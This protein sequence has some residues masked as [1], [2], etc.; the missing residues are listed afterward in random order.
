VQVSS[1]EVEV[2]GNERDQT[3][4]EVSCEVERRVEERFSEEEEEGEEEEEKAREVTPSRW[5]VVETRSWPVSREKS[6]REEKGR[7][8]EEAH[9]S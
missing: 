1:A 8:R 3:R 5:A 6:E 7:K 9:Q 4:R 2:D